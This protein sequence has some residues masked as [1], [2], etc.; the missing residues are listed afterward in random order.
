MSTI[1]NALIW[2]SGIWGTNLWGGEDA[3]TR[4]WRAISGEG[5]NISLVYE[6][7]SNQ[8]QMELN[9]FNLRYSRG[10]QI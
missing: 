7:R 5:Q 10:G 1:T 9:G 2:G 6:A 3:T 4:G 8:S